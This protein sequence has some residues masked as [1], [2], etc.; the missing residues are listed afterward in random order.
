MKTFTPEELELPELTPAQPTASGVKTFTPKD[1]E[2]P[3]AEDA[4]FA[5]EYREG[6]GK[7]W[8]IGKGLE[9]SG[10]LLGRQAGG[11]MEYEE[12]GG[13]LGIISRALLGDKAGGFISK[14]AGNALT[15]QPQALVKGLRILG[16]DD[17]AG[18]SS[19]QVASEYFGKKAQETRAEREKAD[20]GNITGMIA[21]GAGSMAPSLAAG[22]AGIGTMALASGLQV[23]GGTYADAI[24]ENMRRN[25]GMTRQQAADRAAVPAM[26]DGL[27]TALLTRLVPGGESAIANIFKQQG[28]KAAKDYGAKLI[29]QYFKTAAGRLGVT[30]AKE[31]ALEGI[32]EGANQWLSGAIERWTFNPD[33]S[34]DEIVSEAGLAGS[35]GMV[36]GAGMGGVGKLF[37]RRDV[38]PPPP[39]TTSYFQTGLNEPQPPTAGVVSPIDELIGSTRVAP[40]MPTVPEI[41]PPRL[42][43]PLSNRQ[44][45]FGINDPRVSGEAV[46]PVD[47]Y[48]M[49]RSPEIAAPGSALPSYPT[50]GDVTPVPISRVESTPAPVAPAVAPAVIPPTVEA[51]PTITKP[52]AEPLP[53]PKS[54]LSKVGKKQVETSKVKNWIKAF[55][56]ESDPFQ[57][58]S[59]LERV[60]NSGNKADDSDLIGVLDRLEEDKVGSNAWNVA[61]AVAQNPSSSKETKS[62]ALE[63]RDEWMKP[64]RT[65]RQVTANEEVQRQKEDEVTPTIKPAVVG[66]AVEPV[67]QPTTPPTELPPVIPAAVKKEAATPEPVKQSKPFDSKAAKAQKK[68]L[69]DE[70]DKAI[71]D[72]PQSPPP[73][74][75][76]A[77]NQS[78]EMADVMLRDKWFNDNQPPKSFETYQIP[79][80]DDREKIIEEGKA[81]YESDLQAWRDRLEAELDMPLRQK[82]GLENARNI[83]L[84]RELERRAERQYLP[85]VTIEVPGDGTFHII[86]SK[87]ALEKFRE[88][89]QRFPTSAGTKSGPK[90]ASGKPTIP[91]PVDKFTTENVTVAAASHVST[92]VASRR[93]ITHI[94]SDGEVTVATDGRRLVQFEKGIGGTKENPK[95]FT[96]KGQPLTKK[97]M[98][99]VGN[100]PNYKH[101]IPG[102][103]N[104]FLALKDIDTARLFTII[105]QAKPGTSD[106]VVGVMLYRNADGSF[107]VSSGSEGVDYEHNVQPDA[108]LIGSF[109]PDY[110]I[111]ALNAARRIGNEKVDV[112]VSLPGY[113]ND[114]TITPVVIKSKG[115]KVVIMPIRVEESGRQ[116]SGLKREDFKSKPTAKKAAKSNGKSV[117]R[118]ETPPPSA[119]VSKLTPM[120]QQ[121]QR[122][123]A[124]IAKTNPKALLA[125]RL[126][127]FYEFFF[128]DAELASGIMGVTKTKRGEVAMTGVPYHAANGY[129]QKLIDAGYEVAVVDTDGKPEPGKLAER[130]VTE[131]LKPETPAT[132]PSATTP[133]QSTAWVT[134]WLP[135]GVDTNSRVNKPYWN[136]LDKPIAMPVKTA[137]NIVTRKVQDILQDLMEGLGS[138][139][140]AVIDG[141]KVQ[142]QAYSAGVL[143]L[144]NK[145]TGDVTGVLVRNRNAGKRLGGLNWMFN[146]NGDWVTPDKTRYVDG[147][148]EIIG[149]ARLKEAQ[150]KFDQTFNATDWEAVNAEAKARLAQDE[151]TA[152]ASAPKAADTP[153]EVSDLPPLEHLMLVAD[154]AGVDIAAELLP[155]QGKINARQLGSAETAELILEE[156]AKLTGGNDDNATPEMFRRAIIE[157][158]NITLRTNIEG[159]GYEYEN[160][161]AEQNR[162]ENIK[163]ATDTAPMAQ[164]AAKGTGVLR[165]SPDELQRILLGAD[166]VSGRD[167]GRGEQAVGVAE[168]EPGGTLLLEGGLELRSGEA[169]RSDTAAEKVRIYIEKSPAIKTSGQAFENAELLAGKI[170]RGNNETSGGLASEDFIA[171]LFG[172]LTGLKIVFR[173]ARNGKPGDMWQTLAQYRPSPNGRFD[174]I[175]VNL[176][177]LATYDLSNPMHMATVTAAVTEEL[178]HSATF[179]SSTKS[180]LER[181]WESLSDNEKSAVTTVYQGDA[182]STAFNGAEYVRMILQKI[183]SGEIT[184]TYATNWRNNKYVVK[185]LRN[186]VRKLM[187]WFGAKPKNNIA[188]QVIARIEGAIRGDAPIGTPLTPEFALVD[189][190]TGWDRI[191]GRTFV[192]EAE[193]R[194]AVDPILAAWQGVDFNLVNDPNWTTG[195]DSQIA[196]MQIGNSITL[197]LAAIDT[198]ERGIELLMH[199]AVGHFGLKGALGSDFDSAMSGIMEALTPAQQAQVQALA[200]RYGTTAANAVPEWVARV[201]ETESGKTWWKRAWQ[202]IVDFFGRVFGTQN[203]ERMT[204]DLLRRGR[205]WLEQDPAKRGGMR[206][207]LV[208]RNAVITAP[209]TAEAAVTAYHGTPHKVDRFSTANIGTGE[210]AQVYGWGL[211]F[212][213]NR[214]VGKQYAN[215]LGGRKLNKSA[216]DKAAEYLL[217]KTEYNRNAALRL[218]DSEYS[219]IYTTEQIA[220]IRSKIEHGTIEFAGNEYTV[221]LNVEPDELLDWDKPLSEQSE[222][223]KNAL[224]NSRSYGAY[225]VLKQLS[226]ASENYL[227]IVDYYSGY[228]MNA[229]MDASD[230]LKSIGIKGIRYLDQGS[231]GKPNRQD[232]FRPNGTRAG[233][234]WEANGKLF[235]TIEEAQAELDSIGTYNYV[236]FDDKDITI[237]HENGKPVSMA[238]AME[239]VPEY[240]LVEPKRALELAEQ[241]G[242]AG[243]LARAQQLGRVMGSAELAAQPMVRV[244]VERVLNIANGNDPTASEEAVRSAKVLTKY[245]PFKSVLLG[246]VLEVLNLEKQLPAGLQDYQRMKNDPALSKEQKEQGV[247]N[248][249]ETWV[250]FLNSFL[251]FKG[252]AEMQRL[253]MVRELAKLDEQMGDSTKP[254]TLEY[255]KL[256]EKE[257]ERLI[258]V[259]VRQGT[260]SALTAAEKKGANRVLQNIEGIN[261]AVRWTINNVAD[262]KTFKT[263]DTL[264]AQIKHVAGP[265][266]NQA[267]GANDESIQQA[268]TI[269]LKDMAQF[270]AIKTQHDAAIELTAANATEYQKNI[271]NIIKDFQANKPGLALNKY[272]QLLIKL[273]KEKGRVADAIALVHRRQQ[274]FLDKLDA[275]GQ[276]ETML[277]EIRRDPRYAE[278][279]KALSDDTRAQAPMDVFDEGNAVV[280]IT[281]FPGQPEIQLSLYPSKEAAERNLQ[282]LTEYENKARDYLFTK[283]TNPDYDPFIGR[284]LEFF[285]NNRMPIL[286]SRGLLPDNPGLLPSLSLSVFT[287]VGDLLW[288]MTSIPHFALLFGRGFGYR[289]TRERME[290]LA[291][292]QVAGAN[293]YR[294]LWPEADRMLLNAMQKHGLK[295]ISEYQEK[296]FN[297]LAALYQYHQL[298]QM[299]VGENIGTGQVV[300]QEDIDLLR[301]PQYQFQRALFDVIRAVPGYVAAT[302]QSLPGA[303]GIMEKYPGLNFL[304]RDELSTG[305][306][307]LPRHW[308]RVFQWLT[309][310][311]SSGR[312]YIDIANEARRAQRAAYQAAM[313]SSAT[314]T[315]ARQRLAEGG[316]NDVGMDEMMQRVAS[317]AGA[318]AFWQVAQGF[319]QFIDRNAH[320]ITLGY[321]NFANQPTNLRHKYK[322]K[323][324]LY[325]IAKRVKEENQPPTLNEL[326]EMIREH[327]EKLMQDGERDEDY[328]IPSTDEIKQ[329]VLLE[330]DKLFRTAYDYREQVKTEAGDPGMA[331]FELR[332]GIS[333]LTKSRGEQLLPGEWYDYGSLGKEAM[334]AQVSNTY[335]PAMIEFEK[336][337]GA[338]IKQMKS[339]K[340]EL[341]ATGLTEAQL[342]KRRMEGL[343]FFS[344][345]EARDALNELEKMYGWLDKINKQHNDIE[346]RQL[347]GIGSVQNGWRVFMRLLTSAIL[348]RGA[349][350]INNFFGGMGGIVAKRTLLDLP[351]QDLKDFHDTAGIT[352]SS[353]GSF[354]GIPIAMSVAKD[355]TKALANRTT[356]SM[357]E[358]FK[359]MT[360]YAANKTQ[361]QA[362]QA[363]N[364]WVS[365]QVFERTRILQTFKDLGIDTNFALRDRIEMYLRYFETGGESVD[366]E[367]TPPPSVGLLPPSYGRGKLT[368]IAKS[369]VKAFKAVL[370]ATT[371]VL[372]QSGVA[373]ID[374]IVNHTAADTAVDWEHFLM[375]LAHQV[376]PG[377]VAAAEQGGYDWRDYASKENFWT[378]EEIAHSNRGSDRRDIAIRRRQMFEDTGMNWEASMVDYWT[379]Y[380]DWVAGGKKGEQPR[381]YRNDMQRHGSVIKLANETNFSDFS[382]RP[383][384]AH[385]G[386]AY[387]ASMFLQGWPTWAAKQMA[388]SFSSSTDKSKHRLLPDK[389]LMATAITLISLALPWAIISMMSTTLRDYYSELYRGFKIK[390]LT[391]RYIADKVLAGEDVDP[392]T[393]IMVAMSSM[394]TMVP[395]LGSAFNKW[396]DNAAKGGFDI[397]QQMLWLNVLND[398]VN[399]VQEATETRDPFYSTL[400]FTA[401]WLL[402]DSAL[403]FMDVLPLEASKTLIGS[404][405]SRT[406]NNIAAQGATLADIE[407]RRS[408]TGSASFRYT[409]ATPLIRGW[410]SAMATGNEADRQ[411][412]W[413]RLV[414]FKKEDLLAKNPDMDPAQAESQARAGAL[415]SIR[416]RNPFIAAIGRMPSEE[417]YKAM[418]GKLTPDNRATLTAYMDR[419]DAALNRDS[420]GTAS[421]RSYKQ[422]DTGAATASGGSRRVVSGLGDTSR[423]TGD[424]DAATGY[425]GAGMGRLSRLSRPS[426]SRLGGGGGGRFS[427]TSRI[428]SVGRTKLPRLRLKS[429]R[430]PKSRLT[431]RKPRLSRRSIA[432]LGK[433]SKLRM[434]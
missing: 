397:N 272:R 132:Q 115:M 296:V 288:K 340:E 129:F 147:E 242:D 97:Q 65:E 3:E 342:R 165:V 270:D 422:P 209:Q 162:P 8:H 215:A 308:G 79:Y 405:E 92:D 74:A 219:E 292:M 211:Y 274:F 78:P 204:R 136:E 207:R 226:K 212:A 368:R 273:G 70:I 16:G 285:L 350:M 118:P 284:S 425:G 352:S 22:P 434:S 82:Y 283:D 157:A 431:V 374:A 186:L 152:E 83:D 269:L 361:A 432:R 257:T 141:K 409:P 56:S 127:D 244:P 106:R 154:N 213:E 53:Q 120:M 418:M 122:M 196:G 188:R 36:L 34:W 145:A 93:I 294:K 348:T 153:V 247:L 101:V 28:E 241:T 158:F 375:A 107:G 160:R 389:T 371:E 262:W 305:P 166:M 391:P 201:A 75:V 317:E 280:R 48:F 19:G 263:P 126:G 421:V 279:G 45:T 408:M 52:V 159:A 370:L 235:N 395:Y 326:A 23:L 138:A 339:K 44:A 315:I 38:E 383:L 332:T 73:E 60:A 413:N 130:K 14:I 252:T 96:S 176:Q 111:D 150:N 84:K 376:M 192:S 31:G 355:I 190:P 334:L 276:M 291:K 353:W 47:D 261:R 15:W 287:K 358:L 27:Q 367:K 13:N 329:D 249:L 426:I 417:E 330:I 251:Q 360:G 379:R 237:T 210:G 12:R 30:L 10:E 387:E 380:T 410:M 386:G 61:W 401:R 21:E 49:R 183:F 63:M 87:D 255:R 275:I 43:R 119:P 243:D 258:A 433:L 227:R 68:Y 198:V 248:A 264:T 9:T 337:L 349:P 414:A 312:S 105:M 208:T 223:V 58:N 103:A 316:N 218:L 55:D 392:K 250:Q 99:E 238:E 289:F 303:R 179:R 25:P 29:N 4:T 178:L 90:I 221:S 232:T 267:V 399:T 220:E 331:D 351:S 184:E 170:L 24:D 32:E 169:K 116:W 86:Q 144:R 240:S 403:R 81:K 57:R 228:R 246:P 168:L 381:F 324:A 385:A 300:M 377:K 323:D 42:A 202:A 239:M 195:G 260:R 5:E 298:N 406:A 347:G 91:G 199:E 282:L 266:Y 310:K 233:V 181:V 2:L 161:Q 390:A 396:M 26:L 137:T 66:P 89:A 88:M 1:L 146:V 268:A 59:I 37:G 322:Y 77:M 94:Y 336:T 95:L 80:S 205:K 320:S 357:L 40:A 143:W 398:A 400:R 356:L 309:S 335:K 319:E 124:E 6:K 172:K 113:E 388:Y 151:G 341:L 229:Q 419:F 407:N 109:S 140:A 76:A 290:A 135:D 200:D 338:L 131:I 416:S 203:A 254:G 175:E 128:D 424:S 304:F 62:R 67:V 142:D 253:K 343:D 256:V 393:I 149:S 187:D 365:A 234:K 108:K 20:P 148:W 39:D 163:P 373:F 64:G 293:V 328:K 382:V 18:E 429:L 359:Q 134:K 314:V 206:D 362:I 318:K 311:D 230:F 98:E 378:P 430:L 224:I 102:D 185:V 411:D 51:P 321:I 217:R 345:D 121:Y 325:N 302:V 366:V 404:L 427:V 110:L 7:A 402:P 71:T 171:K 306:N 156:L 372:G 265:G 50:L 307:T 369:P 415:T 299:K 420:G 194:A 286:R 123:K 117:E 344:Y 259:V 364:E 54:R 271:A 222:K 17:L 277:D 423:G 363:M 231:R 125:Y 164:G 114:S 11:Y 69:L 133:N 354:R 174:L 41:A 85:H 428:R 301:G 214:E 281:G 225:S 167:T 46:S 104:L 191:E 139:K 216:E 313:Q 155:F 112:Y 278:L 346:T 72:A 189:S 384:A 33:K 180:E 245:R 197:N 327:E 182:G 394:A 193:L 412:Y 295:T 173:D 100:F 236:I 35:V 333:S 177:T 297:P